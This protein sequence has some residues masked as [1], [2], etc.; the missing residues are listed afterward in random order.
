MPLALSWSEHAVPL[1]EMTHQERVV[2]DLML[3]GIA[4]R[5]RSMD[6]VADQ[7]H[8]GITPGHLVQQ[9]EQGAAVT[10]AGLVAVR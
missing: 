9:L 7:L 6:L 1:K 10:V 2:A 8:E 4:V 5:G 3:T